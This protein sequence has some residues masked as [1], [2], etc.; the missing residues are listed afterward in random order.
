M[1][2]K[3]LITS[4][5]I[6]TGTALWWCNTDKI[7]T[8]KQEELKNTIDYNQVKP[9]HDANSIGFEVAEFLSEH[10]ETGVPQAMI[11]LLANSKKEI[12]WRLDVINGENLPWFIK[13]KVSSYSNQKHALLALRKKL[14]ASEENTEWIVAFFDFTRWAWWPS[15][16]E[17]IVFSNQRKDLK[18]TKVFKLTNNNELL[19]NDWKYKSENIIN[20]EYIDFLYK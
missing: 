7:K 9:I 12:E 15:S 2:A 20:N 3:H 4:A 13:W 1:K 18:D 5:A 8:E 14:S 6:I 17:L 16:S 11:D 10:Q 19:S